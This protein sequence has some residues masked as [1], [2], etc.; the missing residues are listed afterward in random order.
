MKYVK[1]PVVVEAF[2]FGVDEYPEWFKFDKDGEER[3]IVYDSYNNSPKLDLITRARPGDYIIKNNDDDII[4]YPEGLFKET[5]DL[6]EDEK[7]FKYPVI[8]SEHE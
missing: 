3:Q 1:K 7:P 4:R 2:Q 5:Y 6:V 8:G